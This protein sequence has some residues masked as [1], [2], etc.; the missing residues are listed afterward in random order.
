LAR[1]QADGISLTEI[2]I[3]A[4]NICFKFPKNKRDTRMVE[5]G[6]PGRISLDETDRDRYIESVLTR[7]GFI[8]HAA[9]K[10]LARAGIAR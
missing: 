9:K 6:R 4:M 5:L 2:D 3:Q 10:Q 8:N 7:W 1:L